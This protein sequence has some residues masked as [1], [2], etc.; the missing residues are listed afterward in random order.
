MLVMIQLLLIL[1]KKL[2]WNLIP[3]QPPY[4]NAKP[5]HPRPHPIPPPD[6]HSHATTRNFQTYIQ[7][8]LS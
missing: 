5:N 2:S 4:P 3:D 6:P 1:Y 7:I 8:F